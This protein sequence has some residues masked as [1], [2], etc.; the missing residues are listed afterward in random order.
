[1]NKK[2]EV[3]FKKARL[4]ALDSDFHRQHVGC[5]ITYK[6][7]PISTGSCS[8]KTH[9][10]QKIYNEYRQP[11]DD[12]EWIPKIHA[13]ISALSKI[14]DLNLNPKK[15]AVYTYRI[16]KDQNN[17]GT[18]HGNRRGSVSGS[19]ICTESLYRV[20]AAPVCQNT[21]LPGPSRVIDLHPGFHEPR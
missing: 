14:K 5:V 15:L 11:P 17:K 7:M 18:D 16:R 4:A 20:P 2:K 13:E 3:I 19:F 6:G 21:D 9:P 12:S 1:M 10:Y 8:E